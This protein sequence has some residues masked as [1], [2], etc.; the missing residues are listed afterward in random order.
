MDKAKIVPIVLLIIILGVGFV[1]YNF[2]VQNIQ[3][4]QN[5]QELESLNNSLQEE[6]NV[7]EQRN[8]RSREKNRELNE[9][10]SSIN[11]ELSRIEEENNELESRYRQVAR[12]RDQ[13]ADKLKE[14]PKEVQVKE[15][16]K[17][18]KAERSDDYW[19]DFIQ[20]KAELEA[21]VDE[22]QKK[23]L[24]TQSEL[25]KIKRE[26]EEMSLELDKYEQKSEELKQKIENKQR[27]L[28]VISMDLVAEREERGQAVE[29]VKKLRNKNSS[30]KRELIVINRQKGK[31]QDRLKE[32]LEKKN[33][34]EEKLVNAESILREKSLDFKDLQT[35][36]TQTIKEGKKAT[37]GE[38]SSVELPPIVVSSDSSIASGLKGEIIAVNSPESFVVFDLGEA[39]GVRPGALLKVM[40]GNREIATVEVIETRKNISAAD[41]KEVVGGFNIQEGDIIISR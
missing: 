31:L 11:K 23:V 2:Y 4:K 9:R 19:A 32:T 15:A 21:K 6:K 39:S 24:N 10:L 36:L 1:A 30:L 27:A 40:R 41:I 3:I 12:E 25:A 7:L 16:P 20:K 13:L 8:Q 33:M 26:N 38:S 14:R 17:V 35:D 28:R 22:L 29:E 5:N 37:A 18:T 34:L